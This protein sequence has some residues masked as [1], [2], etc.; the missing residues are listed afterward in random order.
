MD[1]LTEAEWDYFCNSYIC[2]QTNTTP[3]NQII[4]GTPYYNQESKLEVQIKYSP[5]T[6]G[7]TLDCPKHRRKFVAIL[8][9]NGHHHVIDKNIR[10]SGAFGEPIKRSGEKMRMT[11]FQQT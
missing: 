10:V 5:T 6:T 8:I 9:D 2:N 7:N 11:C 4:A 3:S 1:N